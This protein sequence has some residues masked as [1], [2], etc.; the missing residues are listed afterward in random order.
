MEAAARA[1][2][3]PSQP[4]TAAGPEATAKRLL[5]AAE[6]EALSQLAE[7][8]RQ[9]PSASMGAAQNA[10]I[11]AQGLHYIEAGMPEERVHELE[12][13]RRF[14]SSFTLTG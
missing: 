12:E 13:A 11:L 9:L 6:A 7:G 2:A 5:A 8:G 4:A 3:E 10:A 14:L 1:D